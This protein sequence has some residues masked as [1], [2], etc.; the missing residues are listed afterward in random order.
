MRVHHV[1]ITAEAIGIKESWIGWRKAYSERAQAAESYSSGFVILV[2]SFTSCQSL[3]S[4][5]SPNLSEP[6]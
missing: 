4:G 2:L 3:D 6:H 5:K 1:L